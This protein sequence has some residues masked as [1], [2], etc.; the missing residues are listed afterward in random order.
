MNDPPRR[1]APPLA[2]ALRVEGFSPSGI[3]APPRVASTP[4][5]TLSP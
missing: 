5:T 4:G 2:L 3:Y 1:T